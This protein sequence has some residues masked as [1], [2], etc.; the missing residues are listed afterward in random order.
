MTF[1]LS[2]EIR[3]LNVNVSPGSSVRH[4]LCS[5]VTL[6][7]LYEPLN[8]PNPTVFVCFLPCH[9]MHQENVI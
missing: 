6:P 7:H 2:M 1:F 3:Q 4:K 9:V 5:S 8:L